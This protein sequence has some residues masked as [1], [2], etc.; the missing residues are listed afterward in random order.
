M[1]ITWQ[2]LRITPLS[3]KQ[4]LFFVRVQRDFILT[5]SHNIAINYSYLNHRNGNI[6][7]LIY[8]LVDKINLSSVK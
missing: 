4:A 1:V 7:L 8:L 2:G 3:P 6:S 5:C